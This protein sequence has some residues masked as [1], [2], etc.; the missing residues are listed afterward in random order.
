M[1]FSLPIVTSVRRVLPDQRTDN[2]LFFNSL[3][4]RFKRAF[5]FLS[6][7]KLVVTDSDSPLEAGMVRQIPPTHMMPSR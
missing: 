2:I 5:V 1:R 4:A 6:Y 7:Q 3:K